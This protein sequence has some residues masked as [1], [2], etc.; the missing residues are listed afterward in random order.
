MAELK[1]SSRSLHRYWL[2]LLLVLA[3]L[4]TEWILRKRQGVV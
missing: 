2:P 3:L 1:R 4:A